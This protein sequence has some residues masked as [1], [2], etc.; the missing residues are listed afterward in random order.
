MRH[1]SI[2]ILL[3]VAGSLAS[4]E[5]FLER[6]QAGTIPADQVLVDEKGVQGL[7]NGAYINLANNLYGGRLQFISDLMGDQA[8]GILY[9][10]D[11]GEI[12][13]RKTSIFGAY[14]NDFYRNAYYIIS[15]ANKALENLDKTSTN[16]S[17]IEGQ[18]KFLRAIVH[19]EMVRLFAQPYG[20]TPDNNHPGIPLRL[21]SSV[22][23]GDRATVKQVYDAIITDLMAADGLLPP[24][25]PVGY[26]SKWVAK[27]FLAKVFFQ[28]NNFQQA[29]N[30]SNEVI[31]SNEFFLDDSY[32]YRFSLDA[33]GAGTEEG[34]FVIRNV[35]NVL[36]PG[37]E[38][39]DRYR[40]DGTNFQAQSDFHVTDLYYNQAT[41][42]NDLRRFWYEKNA[43]GYNMITKYNLNQFDLPIVHLT[44]MVLIRAESGAE[45][46]GAS[47]AIAIDDI[48]EILTR[49][50]GGTS[51][52]LSAS[53]SAALVISTTRTQREFEMIAEGNRLQ[54]IKRIGA[55]SGVNID[56]RGSLWNCPGLV[57][58]FPNGEQSANTS[59][60]MNPEG[61]CL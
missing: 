45:L 7:L 44:E 2:F 41:Q 36:S 28:Q 10:E 61:G 20:F 51:Q 34:I 56:R 12:Y 9:T 57:L 43:A 21:Q 29:F 23:P 16:R 58:Q 14:K 1:I 49:A 24:A 39:R 11:F 13:K 31:E 17:F 40:S 54:E 32:D 8:N 6:E 60:L 26:P 33:G 47:L 15:Q 19:F 52:N 4:C 18:A 55:R 59:F 50:Y 5:K 22:T 25:P 37:G 38:L 30:Y 46:G 27:A 48:N 53:A 35:P 42:S 3:L